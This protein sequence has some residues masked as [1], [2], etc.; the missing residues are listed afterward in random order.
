MSCLVRYYVERFNISPTCIG[1]WVPL[2]PFNKNRVSRLSQFAQKL[3]F[4]CRISGQIQRLSVLLWL[5]INKRCNNFLRAN[6]WWKES[7]ADLLFDL[8][9][10]GEGWIST[11]NVK[12]WASHLEN[13]GHKLGYAAEI[14]LSRCCFNW[15]S[16]VLA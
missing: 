9:S 11:F 2:H 6:M 5:S 12:H 8:G 15:Y 10:N 16:F 14:N 1:F 13:C 4:C 7:F 3:F